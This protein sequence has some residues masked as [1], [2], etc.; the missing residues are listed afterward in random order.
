MIRE[1]RQVPRYSANL[2]GRLLVEGSTHSVVVEDLGVFG[3]SLNYAPPMTPI[4]EC[5]LAIEWE[6]RHFR[7]QAMVAWIKAQSKV[8]LRFHGTDAENQELLRRV[9]SELRMKPLV[10]LKDDG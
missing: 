8:G 5:E 4:Q 7:T 6:G 9:C 2:N 10:R 1:R 3:C